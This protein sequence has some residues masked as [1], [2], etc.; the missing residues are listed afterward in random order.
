MKKRTRMFLLVMGLIFGMV[1]GGSLASAQTS[2]NTLPATKTPASARFDLSG[3]ISSTSDVGGPSTITLQGSG[4]MSGADSQFDLTVKSSTAA[5]QGGPNSLGMS[6]VVA[7]NKMYFKFSGLDPSSDNQWFV[8]DVTSSAVTPEGAMPGMPGS[9]LMDPSLMSAYKITQVGKETLSGAQTTKYQVDVDLQ[10]L[11]QIANEQS[12]G[13]SSSTSQI[14]PD[15]KFTMW[16]W[17]G[18]ANQYL[19][20]FK[21]QLATTISGAG[22]PSSSVNMDLT[23]SFH[24]FDTAVKIVAPENAKPL[25]LGNTESGP[26]ALLSSGLVPLGGALGMPVGMMS[27]RPAGMPTTGSSNQADV[28]PWLLMGAVLLAGGL[29]IRRK[30][31]WN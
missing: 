30:A 31:A 13:T 22:L 18:D 19:Y 28:A 15:S 20:Q 21:L 16:I 6:F 14:S 24:D 17:I 7:G 23:L 29:V 9:P 5:A 25:D 3:T 11:Q 12:G 26:G 1:S 10:K 2:Q 4:A 8:T 27:G